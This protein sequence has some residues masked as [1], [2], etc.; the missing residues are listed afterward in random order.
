MEDIKVINPHTPTVEPKA[1]WG[2]W[3][4]TPVPVPCSLGDVMSQEL[5]K[6]LQVQEE[7]ASSTSLR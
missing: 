2:G 7:I 1:A 4:K 6:E 5:A 3:G